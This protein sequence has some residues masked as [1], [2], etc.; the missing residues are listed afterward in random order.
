MRSGD[1]S[2]TEKDLS[3][4]KSTIILHSIKQK[5]RSYPYLFLC[6]MEGKWISTYLNTYLDV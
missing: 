4:E 5:N 1:E 6:E 2:W 3:N